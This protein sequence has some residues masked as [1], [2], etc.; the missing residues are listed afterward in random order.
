MNKVFS[1]LRIIFF[2]IYL[3]FRIIN[4]HVSSHTYNLSW[5]FL[6]KSFITIYPVI[7]PLRLRC[8]ILPES[9]NGIFLDKTGIHISSPKWSLK[10]LSTESSVQFSCSIVS[11]SLRP[12]GQQ[13][14]SPPCPSP[15][16]EAY[17]NSC[18]LSR[19]CH[20]TISSSVI[21]LSSRPQSLPVLGSF[22]MSWLF[23]SGG[24]SIGASA[25]ASVL[26]LNIQSSSPLRCT[27]LVSLLSK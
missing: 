12:H 5:R 8:L 19:W 26:P 11:N 9:D 23:T 22:P 3:R 16:P 4:G 27:G 13:H 7:L 10:Y 24:Q 15:N 2:G 20:P 1:S 6:R 14:S 21:P 18:P 17:S 25:L